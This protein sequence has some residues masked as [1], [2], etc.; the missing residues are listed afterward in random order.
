MEA[1]VLGNN[2]EKNL[3]NNVDI[4]LVGEVHGVEENI[5]TKFEFIKYLVTNKQ[6]RKIIIELGYYDSLGINEYIT[7]GNENVLYNVLLKYKKNYMNSKWEIDFWKKIHIFNSKL[8]DEYKIKIVGVDCNGN[9]NDIFKYIIYLIKQQRYDDYLYKLAEIL[10]I[11]KQAIKVHCKDEFTKAKSALQ[12]M[13]TRLNFNDE[14][15]KKINGLLY[16]LMAHGDRKIYP[17]QRREI[18]EKYIYECMLRE[19][20]KINDEGKIFGQFGCKHIYSI[21]NEI[22]AASYR[23]TN[24]IDNKCVR[25]ALVYDNCNYYIIRNNKRFFL[26]VDT[27]VILNSIEITEIKIGENLFILKEKNRDNYYIQIKSDSKRILI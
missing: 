25:I 6:V 3:W 19:V 12:S 14:Y 26:K 9:M 5:Q 11:Y 18:R 16:E 23:L 24:E 10:H 1:K 2:F 8:P 7:S 13:A 22:Q 20:K 4:Y 21:D 27:K 17:D 15:Q